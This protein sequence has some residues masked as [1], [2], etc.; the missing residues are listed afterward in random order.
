MSATALTTVTQSQAPA[1]RDALLAFD[2]NGDGMVDMVLLWNDRNQVLNATSFV[3][4]GDQSASN[5]IKLFSKAVSSNLNVSTLHQVA[6]LPADANGDGVVDLVQVSQSS[7]VLSIQSF[8][9]D[10]NGGLW[11]GQPPRF[12]AIR[13]GVQPAA[14]G[15]E[16][17]RADLPGQLLAGCRRRI[18]RDRIWLH[19][20]RAIPSGRRDQHGGAALANLVG[21]ANGDGKADLLYTYLDRQNS[22]QVQ[23]LTSDGKI[24]DLVRQI[25]NAGR[26]DFHHVFDPEQS[27]GLSSRSAG[28]LSQCQRAAHVAHLSPAQFPTQEVIGRAICVVSGYTLSSDARMNRYAYERRF[29]MQYEDAR[30]GLTGRGGRVCQGDHH[31]PGHRLAAGA[32]LFAGFSV[33]G[34]PGRRKRRSRYDRFR[35]KGHRA[36]PRPHCPRLPGRA[37]DCHGQ[38]PGSPEDGGLGLALRRGAQ[39][40]AVATSHRYDAYGNP[41]GSVWHGYVSGIDPDAV[42]P[43]GAFR[44]AAGH[45]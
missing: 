10:A 9:S 22:V 34:P 6:I 11:R 21:D 37:A 30:I 14:D 41:T 16:W 39:D 38:G 44:R 7:A 17:R 1:N 19:A 29:A 12:L 43:V 27:R 31:G 25:T 40:Y 20:R 28:R 13:V 42:N 15:R 24:P 26:R 2:V 45:G 23:P 35:R 4:Q 5:G 32:A 36:A 18:A 33:P 8:L 3:S